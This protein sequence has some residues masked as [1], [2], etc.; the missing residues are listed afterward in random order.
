MFSVYASRLFE[1]NLWASLGVA[2]VSATAAGLR[3]S[4]VGFLVLRLGSE[5]RLVLQGSPLLLS[6]RLFL[7]PSCL[8]QGTR[9]SNELSVSSLQCLDVLHA[10]A[11]WLFL[12]NCSG[13][14]F[15]YLSVPVHCRPVTRPWVFCSLVSQNQ[16]NSLSRSPWSVT[17][18]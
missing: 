9:L 13:Q 10:P 3:R 15:C 8:S 12:T 6:Y 1:R 2:F 11:L 5:L 7:W 14:Q 17:R 4:R 16:S 18:V